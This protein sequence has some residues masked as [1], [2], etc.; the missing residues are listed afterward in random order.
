MRSPSSVVVCW[1]GR[2]WIRRAPQSIPSGTL[3]YSKTKAQLWAWLYGGRR[4]TSPATRVLA[5]L[6]ILGNILPE[7]RTFCTSALP[8]SGKGPEKPS[9]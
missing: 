3:L 8:L 5:G 1:N 9:F 2:V 4:E 7:P 6:I